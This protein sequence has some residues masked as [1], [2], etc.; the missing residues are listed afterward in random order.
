MVV[1]H[2]LFAAPTWNLQQHKN[3]LLKKERIIIFYF[4]RIRK[5]IPVCKTCLKVEVLKVAARNADLA[6]RVRSPVAL[7]SAAALVPALADVSN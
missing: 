3:Y 6:L 2:I 7:R 4:F 1:L 5:Y